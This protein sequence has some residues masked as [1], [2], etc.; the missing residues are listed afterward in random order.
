[1]HRLSRR[2]GS[3]GATLGALILL[4]HCGGSDLTLPD[5]TGAGG[6][7]KVTGDNQRGLPG[8]PLAESLTVKVTDRAGEPLSNLR[9]AFSLDTDAPGGQVSPAQARTRRDGVARARWVLGAGTGPQA[10]VA[11]VVGSGGLEVRFEASIGS[12]DASRLESVSG[13]DQSGAIGTALG[14]PLVVRVTD[15][16]GNPVANVSVEWDGGDGSVDPATSQTGNDGKASTSWTLGSSIGSHTAT[17]SSGSLN[18]SPVTFTATAVAGSADR[19][20]QVSGNNQ[21]ANPGAELAQ[22]VVVRL[23]DREGN[24]IFGRAVT[25]VVGAGGGSVASNTSTTDG[26]GEARVRWTLG[27]TS[28]TN[29][30]N[31]VVSGVG[32]VGFV[33]TAGS[34]GGGGGSGPSRLQFRVQP[35]D[36]RRDRKISP[37]VVV[38]VLDRDGNRVTDEV[39]EVKLELSGDDHGR[40]EGDTDHHTRS[41]VATFDDL[42]VNHEGDYRLR[43]SADGLSTVDSERFRVHRK[44]NQGGDD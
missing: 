42:K 7:V 43:A 17:A 41:G 31:A 8:S 32:V 3:F 25:W 28:G 15:Q 36:V 10:V 44:D 27:P 12:G 37:P 24:G 33:A 26:D 34:G 23:V 21:S 16:L 13:D 35:S 38:E 2:L 14:D 4:A 18:G 30:L 20:V 6:I 5:D 11:R 22:P 19:L 40:L 9:V 29:T 39:L 1:V